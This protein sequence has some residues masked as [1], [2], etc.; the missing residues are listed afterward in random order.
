MDTAVSSLLL[1]PSMTR[2]RVIGVLGGMSAASTALYYNRLNAA[3]RAHLGGLHGASLL[4]R[5]VDFAPIA[6]M[7]SAGEW[8]RA[9]AVLNAE[10]RALERGGAELLLLATNTMHCVANEIMDG[11][12]IPLLHIGDATASAIVRDGLRRPGLMATAFTMEGDVPMSSATT[13]LRVQVR[14]KIRSD[15][16]V[17][18]VNDGLSDFFAYSTRAHDTRG[19]SHI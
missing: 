14:N 8:R 6:A 17:T 3:A 18:R 7:Q 15:E 13:Y 4:I 19:F 10:A 11:V 16:R 12:R 5:S 1:L 9:G 2:Q